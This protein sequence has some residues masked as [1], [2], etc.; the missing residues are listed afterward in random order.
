MYFF[1]FLLEFVTFFLKTLILT[2]I[3]KLGIHANR[4]IYSMIACSIKSMQGKMTPEN[5]VFSICHTV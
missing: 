3:K 1:S 5:P 2:T 4:G